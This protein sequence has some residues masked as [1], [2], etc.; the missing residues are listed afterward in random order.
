MKSRYDFLGR[1][2]NTIRDMNEFAQHMAEIAN[3][4]D[5]ITHTEIYKG[6]VIIVAG[7]ISAEKTG[8]DFYY[9]IVWPEDMKQDQTVHSANFTLT[10]RKN[11]IEEARRHVDGILDANKPNKGGN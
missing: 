10:G 8:I 6:T 4:S 3:S 2:F 5:M 9:R 7:I 1:D 11:S